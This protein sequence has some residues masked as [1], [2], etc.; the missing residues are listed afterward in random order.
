MTAVLNT[1]DL[2]NV[3]DADRPDPPHPAP[4]ISCPSDG[5][6]DN[7]HVTLSEQTG[8]AILQAARRVKR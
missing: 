7:V 6:S 2:V 4:T 5:R 1:H 8:E 3:P